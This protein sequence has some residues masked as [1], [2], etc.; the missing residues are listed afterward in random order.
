MKTK[1]MAFILAAGLGITGIAVTAQA[2]AAGAKAE[3]PCRHETLHYF[4]EFQRA[5]YYDPTYHISVYFT[6]Y[7]CSNDSCSYI[8]MPEEK[9][10]Y[11][12]HDYEQTYYPDGKV[13]SEC[14]GC[15]DSYYW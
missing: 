15:H 13:K 9:E 4:S 1:L 7:K 14:L 6:G 12:R 11:E 2:Q 5:V 3:E 10:Y 8:A